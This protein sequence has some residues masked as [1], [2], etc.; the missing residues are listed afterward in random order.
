MSINHLVVG[1]RGSGF[2]LRSRSSKSE[3]PLSDLLILTNQLHV[4]HWTHSK[5][6][7]GANFARINLGYGTLGASS[8]YGATRF[9]SSDDTL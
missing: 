9:G 6:T 1:V 3:L 5:K 8:M 7:S 2:H 4:C